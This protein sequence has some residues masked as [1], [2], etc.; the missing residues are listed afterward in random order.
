MSKCKPS[1]FSP[2][3]LEIMC[4]I[5]NRGNQVEVKRERD[6]LVVVEIKRTALIKSPIKD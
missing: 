5:I 6:N 1:D 2:Q 3:A 4:D